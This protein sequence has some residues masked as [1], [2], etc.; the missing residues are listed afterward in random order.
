MNGILH[1]YNN[2]WKH[3]HGK[4]DVINLYLFKF[5][6]NY[7]ET[8]LTKNQNITTFNTIKLLHNTQTLSCNRLVLIIPLS[9][10]ISRSGRQV[11]DVVRWYLLE[12][13][14]HTIC[15]YILCIQGKCRNMPVRLQEVK[16]LRWICHPECQWFGISIPLLQRRDTTLQS[17][18]SINKLS[19]VVTK[20]S[21]DLSYKLHGKSASINVTFCR[22]ML[23]TEFE[24]L[25]LETLNN[26]LLKK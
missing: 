12:S 7:Y 14:L 5:L 22:N 17:C 26:R 11:F 16:K 8:Q 13:Y 4:R 18:R 23:R 24:M 19:E 3:F 2:Y 9:P 6:E 15:Q 21:K 25:A 10:L 1:L 20:G